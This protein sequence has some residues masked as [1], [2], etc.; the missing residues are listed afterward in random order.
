MVKKNLIKK[1][2]TTKIHFNLTKGVT[3]KI[4]NQK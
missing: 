4:K 1:K 3:K 2:K